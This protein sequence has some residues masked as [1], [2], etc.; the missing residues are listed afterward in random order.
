[1]VTLGP[2]QSSLGIIEAGVLSKRVLSLT[3][4][5]VTTWKAL[6]KQPRAATMNFLGAPRMHTEGL[7]ITD[8]WSHNYFHWLTEALPRLLLARVNGSQAQIV[9]PEFVAKSEFVQESLKLLGERYV[10]LADR[11]RHKFA[12]LTLVSPVAPSGNPDPHVIGQLT[13]KLR[14]SFESPNRTSFPKSDLRLWVS[15]ARSARRQIV[16]EPA[17]TPLLARFGFTIVYPEELSFAEQVDIFSR[18]TVIAGLHGA[19]LTNMLFMAE[20]GIVLEVRREDDAH[21][22]CYFALAS[23]TKQRYGFAL[24]GPL[25]GNLASGDCFLPELEL[26]QAMERLLPNA[27]S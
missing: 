19:G 4:P 26:E 23:A 20:G 6:S 10:I 16:N 11:S 21:N 24:A 2:V 22:N 8:N 14:G 17:L 7:W 5:W 18:A 12:N 25:G 13:A 3:H 27:V 15:R 9:V 1:M